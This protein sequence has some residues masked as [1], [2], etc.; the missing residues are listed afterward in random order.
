MVLGNG[1]DESVVVDEMYLFNPSINNFCKTFY[2]NLLIHYQANDYNCCIS[3][4]AG[5][6]NVTAAID[7]VQFSIF[8]RQHRCWHN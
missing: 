3:Y 1:N 7:G 8:I 4:T 2:I 6:C 5:Y